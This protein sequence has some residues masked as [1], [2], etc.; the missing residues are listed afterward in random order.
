VIRILLC[1]D[2]DMVCEGLT[3]I[4]TRAPDMQVVA[5]AH[6]G[7]EAIELAERHRPDLVLM[8]LKMP[9]MDGVTAT[10]KLKECLPL[11]KV[12]VLTTYDDSGWVLD[13]VRGGAAGYLLK[14][15]PRERL[16]EAI[17]DTM[18]GRT[19]LD[20]SVAGHVLAHMLHGA[21]EPMPRALAELGARE[22]EVLAL[23]GEGLDNH[24]IARRLHLSEGTVRNYVS[25]I[26]T[27]LDVS[28]RTKAAVLAI[29]CGLTRKGGRD[30]T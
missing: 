9:V 3:A 2:Q 1:D 22:R 17:R 7:A 6:D 30:S 10:R 27:K 20:S 5:A 28:D 24:E 14:D 15:T 12:L 29:R 16:F 11:V 8:D 26:L 25:G 23:V 21:P 4:L 13:A 18:A 19:P